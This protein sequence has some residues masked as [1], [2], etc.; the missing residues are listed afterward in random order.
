MMNEVLLGSV[1]VNCGDYFSRSFLR[2]RRKEVALP[3]SGMDECVVDLNYGF[4]QRQRIAKCS[5]TVYCRLNSRKTSAASGF[6]YK[7]P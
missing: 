1:T 7:K 5:G 6:A 2:R 4:I 3:R